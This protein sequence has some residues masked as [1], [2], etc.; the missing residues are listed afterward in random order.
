LTEVLLEV[1]EEGTEVVDPF[2]GS[3]VSSKEGSASCNISFGVVVVDLE[4][5]LTDEE[6]ERVGRDFS[7]FGFE[8][9]LSVGPAFRL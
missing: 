6:R 4:A 3:E 2:L 9:P 5:L 1:V 7:E 8:Q